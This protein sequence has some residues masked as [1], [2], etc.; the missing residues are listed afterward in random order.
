M[1]LLDLNVKEIA[2]ALGVIPQIIYQARSKLW[3]KLH[4]EG[5]EALLPYLHDLA[6]EDGRE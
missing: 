5:I 2:V 3:P 1:T 6:A 4:L